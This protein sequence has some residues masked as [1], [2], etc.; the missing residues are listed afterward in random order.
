MN[1]RDFII[2][3]V[4][5]ILAELANISD[6][7]SIQDDT[8]LRDD[9]GIDSMNSLMVLMRLEEAIPGFR[10]DPETIEA[11]H[12]ETLLSICMYILSELQ[13]EQIA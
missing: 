11:S 3:S 10:V 2:K 4:R 1:N 13:E 7:D 5:E 6:P 12:L 9:L 8:S